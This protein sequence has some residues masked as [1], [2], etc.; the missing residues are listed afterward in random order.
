M[1]TD[2]WSEQWIP[3]ATDRQSRIDERTDSALEVVI[4]GS[5]RYVD[6]NLHCS[7]R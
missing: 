5:F 3:H 7:N 4:P 2:R 1:D 6:S